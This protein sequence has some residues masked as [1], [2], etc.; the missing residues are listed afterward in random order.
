MRWLIDSNLLLRGME[1]ADPRY[2]VTRQ[3]VGLLL[4]RQDVLRFTLQGLTEFWN[5]CTRPASARGG[6]G[7]SLAE[8]DR[9]MQVVERYFTF[10]E[11]PPSVRTHWRQLVVSHQVQGVQVHDARLVAAMLAQGV[12]HLLTFNT[13]DFQRYPQIVA[14]ESQDVINGQV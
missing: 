10:L 11:E 3:A 13:K 6:L 9:R 8:T 14:A 4:A 2:P 12:T 5:V 1:R 7:L